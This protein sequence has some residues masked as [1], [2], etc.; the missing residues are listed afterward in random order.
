MNVIP[1]SFA[2]EHKQ[3]LSHL[4]MMISK[5]YL[6]IPKSIR[7]VNHIAKNHIQHGTIIRQRKNII[8]R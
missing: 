6:A 8:F 3:M 5:S 7:Q 2:A 1:V 4:A